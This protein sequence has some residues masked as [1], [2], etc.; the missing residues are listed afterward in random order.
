MLDTFSYVI[1][2]E[3][4][5]LALAALQQHQGILTMRVISCFLLSV[6]SLAV[7]SQ[8]PASALSKG[9]DQPQSQSKKEEQKA[10]PDKRGTPDVPLVIKVIPAK[11]ADANAAKQAEREEEKSADDWIVAR[12]TF[13][14]AIVTGFLAIFTLGLMIYTWRLWRITCQLVDGAKKT[15]E[16]QLRA[17]ISVSAE[18]RNIDNGEAPSANLTIANYGQTPAYGLTQTSGIAWGESFDTLPIP[19]GPKGM[20]NASLLPKEH[21][22]ARVVAPRPLDIAEIAAFRTGTLTLWVYGDLR[23]RDAFDIDRFKKF[24]YMVGGPVGV[25]NSSLGIC[26]EGNEEN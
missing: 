3:R 10:E 4:C 7:Y 14:L 13:A 21:N 24:R 1:G 16:R 26:E 6:F 22:D 17:Y 8:N 20:T 11:G 12:S 5:N 15:A 25:R 18:I 2:S 23:Y 19:T 9:S